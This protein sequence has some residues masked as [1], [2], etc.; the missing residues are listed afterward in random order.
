MATQGQ[1]SR[2]AYTQDHVRD[3][4]HG[5]R[6]APYEMQPTF[7]APRTGPG[8]MAPK[9][10]GNATVVPKMGDLG[11]RLLQDTENSDA[12]VTDAPGERYRLGFV[13]VACLI[14]NRMIGEYHSFPRLFR[15]VC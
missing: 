6:G 8:A 15:L 12:I 3:G 13:D 1:Y 14:I 4:Q 10:P 5:Q 11:G 7:G 2:A 9:R